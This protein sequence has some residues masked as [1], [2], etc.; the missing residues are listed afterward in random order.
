MGHQK[1]ISLNIPLGIKNENNMNLADVARKQADEVIEGCFTN[2]NQF[3]QFAFDK[4]I[5]EINSNSKSGL[6]KLE[7]NP[8][9]LYKNEWGASQTEAVENEI[10]VQTILRLRAE[11]FRVKRTDE[12]LE[13]SWK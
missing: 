11:G 3:T 10:V 1:R 8:C 6:K 4:V 2:I 7:I 12:K 9:T 5:V 13:I